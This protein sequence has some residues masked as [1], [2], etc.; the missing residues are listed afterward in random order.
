MTPHPLIKGVDFEWDSIEKAL[1]MEYSGY[2]T[3]ECESNNE[4][5]HE[6][7]RAHESKGAS[8]RFANET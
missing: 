2:L 4:V 7:D 1:E 8:A 6:N 3:T 5:R